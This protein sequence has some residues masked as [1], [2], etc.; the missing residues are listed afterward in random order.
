MPTKDSK[1][2]GKTTT[3]TTRRRNNKKKVSETDIEGSEQDLPSKKRNKE[4]DI[5]FHV[6]SGKSRAE[7]HQNLFSNHEEVKGS[8]FE[9]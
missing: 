8:L 5:S 9:K 6:V 3:S 1:R 2:E 4:T 7:A